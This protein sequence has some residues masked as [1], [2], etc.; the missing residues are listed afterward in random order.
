MRRHLSIGLIVTIL[1]LVSVAP[2]FA[3]DYGYSTEMS[4][5]EY[6][7]ELQKWQ[8]RLEEANARIAQL[9]QEIADLEDQIASLDDQ[10]AQTRQETLDILSTVYDNVQQALEDYYAD[11]DQLISDLKGLV[12]LS[13]EE[14]L[15]RADEVE[16][17]EE[18]LN[19][20]KE[21]PFSQLDEAM[22][23]I[24]EAESLLERIKAK[25]PEG[26]DSYTVQRGD[27]LWRIAGMSDI[28]SDPYQWVKIWTAN[29]DQINNPDLI[30]PNQRFDI[31][32][33]VMGNK[34]VVASGEFLSRIAGYSEVYGDPFEWQRIYNANQKVISDPNMIYPHMIL[35]IPQN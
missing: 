24:D 16:A 7:A 28:Y 27:Y 12:A 35:N 14:L 4:M 23:K 6:E 11:L 10:I 32:R 13:P 31:P 21:S 25:M 3:Q 33:R 1:A 30:Y 8:Q 2:V 17:A 22:A 18:K 9:E 26:M 34:H 20:L 5:E 29:R 15:R 19:E